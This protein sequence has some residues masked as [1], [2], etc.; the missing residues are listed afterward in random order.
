MSIDNN[1]TD[2]DVLFT[3]GAS[4]G[5][6]GSSGWGVIKLSSDGFVHEYGGFEKLATNNQMELT[7]TIRGLLSLSRTRKTLLLTDSSYV[8]NGIT[9]WL[10]KWQLKDWRTASGSLV[11]NLEHW[12]ELARLTVPMREN[13]L[14]KCI[15]VPAHVGIPGNERADEIASDFSLKKPLTLYRGSLSEY[16]FDL[17]DLKAKSQSKIKKFSSTAWY[18][19][20]IDKQLKRH[21][22]WAECEKRVKG[23]RNALFRKV[24]SKEQEE[25]VLKRWK[26]D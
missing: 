23:K 24:G 18:L 10:K 4:K 1:Y 9:I 6:P 15:H 5:N 3:D 2:K 21:N 13:G 20:F 14:L 8:I 25:E 11:L 19:S 26:I 17:T 12:M 7:A 16:S 22:T